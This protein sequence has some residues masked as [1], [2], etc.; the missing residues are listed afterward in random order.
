MTTREKLEKVLEFIINEENEKASDLLHDVF[1]EKARGIY[2]EIATEDEEIEEATEEEVEEAKSDDDKEDK[3]QVDEADIQDQF[4]D[5]V[6]TDSEMIDQEEVAEEDPIGDEMPMDDEMGDAEGEDPVEDAFMNVEDALDELKAE[7]AQLMGDEEPADMDDEAPVDDM[8]D[9]VDAEEEDPLMMGGND[10]EP[11]EEEL[12]YEQVG[13]GA[14]NVP[15]PNMSET[16]FAAAGG[17]TGAVGSKS[18]VAGKN[19][20][21]GNVVKVNDGSEGDHGD[22]AVKEDN[23]GNVNVPGGK[24]GKAQS[25]VADP[26]NSEE[27]SNKKSPIDGS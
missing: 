6:E 11:V 25:N 27:A 10:E 26:K 4:A 22:N 8:S 7:F 23:A 24:A 2:E 13:E 1:V 16:G 3:E 20:M 17:S 5:E 9:M 21:G 18:P 19:D 14:V 15:D 12:D